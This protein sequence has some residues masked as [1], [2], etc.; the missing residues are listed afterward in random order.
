ME[1]V[2]EGDVKW[3]SIRYELG[4]ADEQEWDGGDMRWWCRVTIIDMMYGT[5]I[6]GWFNNKYI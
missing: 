5:L 6:W 4:P 2:D 3:T 1:P